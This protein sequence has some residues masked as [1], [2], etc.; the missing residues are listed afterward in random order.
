MNIKGANKEKQIGTAKRISVGVAASTLAAV[1]EYVTGVPIRLMQGK[2]LSQTDWTAEPVQTKS[3]KIKKLQRLMG[4]QEPAYTRTH[5]AIAGGGGL[6]DPGGKYGKGIHIW[7]KYKRKISPFEMAVA[8]HELGH[9]KNWAGWRRRPLT[10][11]RVGA[12]PSAGVGALVA[13]FAKKEETARKGAI[14]GSVLPGVML[15]EEA[16]ASARGFK[17]LAKYHGGGIK[18]LGKAL[19]RGQAGGTRALGLTLGS[20]GAVAAVPMLT[21]LFRKKMLSNKENTKT[22][23]CIYQESFIDELEKISG[24][25]IPPQ[26][27]SKQKI[28]PK[29]AKKISY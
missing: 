24:C 23:E 13:A 15:A 16:L 25:K 9:A 7:T 19:F 29:K 11:I 18:G 28:K 4:T 1:P 22:A 6:Y 17:G 12:M 3:L 5:G 21:Y 2:R 8:S 10:W 26:Y 14:A 27:L 20:Y